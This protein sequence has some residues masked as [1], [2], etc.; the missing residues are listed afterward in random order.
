VPPWERLVERGFQDEY[1]PLSPLDEALVR[2]RRALFGEWQS[3]AWLGTDARGRD[4]LARIVWGGRT[5]LSVALVAAAAALAIGV[6]Y[7][8][9]AGLAGGRV[10]E[11]LMRLVDV[12]QSVSFL[13]VV[14]YLVTLLGEQRAGLENVGLGR[15]ALFYLA[16]GAVSWLAMARVVRGQVL[17]LRQAD[18]VRAARLSGASSARILLVHVLPNVL[19]V[20]AVTLTLSVPS[21]VLYEAFLSFLGL[22]IEPPK[23][24]WGLLCASGIEALNPIRLDW[25]LIAFPSLA[26]AAVL[27][28]LNL[29][30]DGLRDA[31]DPRGSSERSLP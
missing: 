1:W 15:E 12:L 26:I 17:A 19:P 5:S 22:G 24:S 8:A 6:L 13:F 18:F 25:W 29:V 9:V 21:I 11:A 16:I 23:V 14:I 31:L 7:G 20:V 28:A 4:L 30:G 27:L 2:V 10:D 3:A